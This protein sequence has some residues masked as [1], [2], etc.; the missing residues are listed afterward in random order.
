[1]VTPGSVT[2]TVY[3]DEAG[4]DYNSDPTDFTVPGLKGMPQFDDVYARS[5]GPI[6]GGASGTLKTVSDQDMKAAGDELRIALETKLR[7]KARADLAPSQVSYSTGLV[8][9]LKKAALSHEKASSEDKA[10]I[11]QRGRLPIAFDGMN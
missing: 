3:A 9:E 7:T 6:T 5:K 8:I 10:L 2:V 1:M 11:E 4:P